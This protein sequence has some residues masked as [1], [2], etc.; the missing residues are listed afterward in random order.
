MTPSNRFSSYFR[1]DTGQLQ[2]LTVLEFAVL[3]AISSPDYLHQSAPK[4]RMTREPKAVI[5]AFV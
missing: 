2:L 1:Q 5:P 3:A 4:K